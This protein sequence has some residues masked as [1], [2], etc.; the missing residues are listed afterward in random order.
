MKNIVLRLML[1][2][3]MLMVLAA[4]S[5]PV[6]E[7]LKNEVKQ[8]GFMF[9]GTLIAIAVSVTIFLAVTAVFKLSKKIL[10]WQRNRYLKNKS[11]KEINLINQPN[12]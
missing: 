12:S 3:F 6:V 11:R 10:S 2:A 1:F 5:V 8:A 9:I 4:K 7:P